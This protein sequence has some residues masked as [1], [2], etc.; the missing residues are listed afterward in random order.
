[1]KKFLR[2]ICLCFVCLFI[3]TGMML[4]YRFPVDTQPFVEKKYAGWNGVLQVWICSK[5]KPGGSFIRW[6]NHCSSSFEKAHDGVYLEF[7]PVQPEVMCKADGSGLYMPDLVLFSPGVFINSGILKE[8]HFF[9]SL[10]NDLRDYGGGKA[11]PLALG[12]YVWAYNPSLCRNAPES[13]ADFLSATLPAGTNEHF[14]NA[15]LLGLLS[16][17]SRKDDTELSM[18]DTGIDLGL[19][20][21]GSKLYTDSP[22]DMFIDGRIPYLPVDAQDIARLAQL[23]ERGIGPDWQT[24]VSGEIACTDQILLAAIPWQQEDSERSK[25]A[26]M[27][28]GH[29]LQPDAQTALADIGAFSVTGET[30]HPSFSVYAETDT[31]LNSRLLWLPVCFSEYSVANSDAIVR[32]FLSGEI[33]A[34]NALRLLGFEGL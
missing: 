10:R 34:K 13:A 24:E 6:L 8:L 25:L 3:S 27:F 17:T 26:E 1:M 2:L 21:S 23:T 11:V 5:W 4:M 30:I 20:S 33:S 7:T 14:Y 9:E 12:G 32:R 18:P 31:L 28:I 22:L 16:D 15:A 19:P 29:L